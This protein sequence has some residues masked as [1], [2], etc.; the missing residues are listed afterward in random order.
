MTTRFALLAGLL[1]ALSGCSSD[2]EKPEPKIDPNMKLELKS[3]PNPG[4]PGGQSTNKKAASG[5]TKAE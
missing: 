3:L 5:G 2:K 1:I 4:L